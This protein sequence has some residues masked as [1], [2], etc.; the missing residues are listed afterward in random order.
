[1]VKTYTL[2][3]YYPLAETTSPR[4]EVYS[5]NEIAAN[6][7]SFHKSEG[8]VEVPVCDCV[9]DLL[10][11]PDELMRGLDKRIASYKQRVV[12]T[13]IDSYLFLLSEKNARDFWV[14]LQKRLDQNKQNAVYMVGNLYFNCKVFSN[15]R[16]ENS[17]DVVA[18][19]D[20]EVTEGTV[21]VDV[22]PGELLPEN[23]Y[24]KSW[25]EVLRTMGKFSPMNGD[26]S[27]ALPNYT[28]KYIGLSNKVNQFLS[29]SEIAKRFYNL[30]S[31][32]SD[33]VL[34]EI[35]MSIRTTDENPK[36]YLKDK[37]GKENLNL[38]SALKRLYD[39]RDCTIWTAYVWMLQNSISRDSC[40]YQVLDANPT[41]ENILSKYSV[42]CTVKY[43]TDNRA[44]KFARERADAL[45]E[46]GSIVEAQIVCF[47]SC[48]KDK[49]DMDVS[50][51]LNCRTKLE[52]QEIIRRVSNS[53]LT[54]GLPA[55]WKNTYLA[56]DDYLS[57]HDYGSN[58]LNE[59]FREYRR[60][61]I[62]NSV[63]SEFVKKAFD[64]E[65]PHDVPTRDSVLHKYANMTD[66][67]LMLVDGM[68]AEYF[69]LVI[70]IAKRNG[71]NIEYSIITQANLPTST[72]YNHI[73]WDKDRQ[74]KASHN[75]DNISHNG[76]IA[77][78]DNTFE[79]DIAETLNGFYE[80]FNR[81]IGG[82]DK[83]EHIVLTADHGCS[84]LAS[85]AYEQKLIQDLP[86]ENTPNDWRYSEAPKG[87]DASQEF[88][89]VYSPKEDKNFW[90]V[91]GYNRL[92]KQGGKIC[93]H[94]G[95]TLEERLVPFIVFSK[96][97]VDV[98]TTENMIEEQFEENDILGDI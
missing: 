14:G 92:P 26:Y 6:L 77:H 57:E 85:I 67:A 51:W 41:A 90:V 98:E 76:A 10:P 97:K 33:D 2:N 12:I 32:F 81:I 31:D 83:Y 13:G 86:W 88:E 74:L 87:M 23:K 72:D 52:C 82:F 95:A 59:Y 54:I 38:R 70:E 78:E 39:L 4:V 79:G 68:G 94:G 55:I 46:I 19:G 40:L 29:I 62:S 35:I 1:M 63:T 73:E 47:I 64:V 30:D 66:T 16:Y 11:M 42:D 3:E 20:E 21:Q 45:K 37:F 22:A 80:V 27:L 84:R 58:V 71:L 25:N 96:A 48:V 61:K 36:D 75:A 17:L 50:P 15:P 56:L 7:L 69:P 65:V 93:V 34:E 91:R 89:V 60:L 44:R 53:D 28:Y 8:V 49:P 9:G 18:L 43:L 5:S 24:L